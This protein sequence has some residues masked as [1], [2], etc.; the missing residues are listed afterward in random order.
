[1]ANQLSIT[2]SLVGVVEKT[3]VHTYPAAAAIDAGCS[4]YLNTDGKWAK[5]DH[6]AGTGVRAVATYTAHIANASLEGMRKGVLDIGNA[7]SGVAYGASLY[8]SSTAGKIDDAITADEE[9]IGQCV[10]AWD[11]TTA[12]KLLRVDL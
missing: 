1:M 3:E 6:D 2:E 10:P 9:E 4:I 11:A 5:A 7:L 12:D 8:L